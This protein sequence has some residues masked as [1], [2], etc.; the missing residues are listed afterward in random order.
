MMATPL[1]TSTGQDEDHWGSV[2]FEANY[3][4]LPLDVL[5]TADVGGRRLVRHLYPHRDGTQIED[6]GAVARK[7]RCKILFFPYGPGDTDPTVYFRQFMKIVARPEAQFFSHPITGTYLARVGEVTYNAEA[8]PRDTIT[9]ECTFEEDTL[10]PAVFEEALA[11]FG[12]ISMSEI[13]ASRQAITDVIAGMPAAPPGG[14]LTQRAY[15]G[16]LAGVTAAA[17][18]GVA[19]A[20]TWEDPTKRLRDANLELAQTITEIDQKQQDL[21]TY[22]D[23]GFY[24]LIT[25]CNDF[26]LSLMQ[27]WRSTQKAATII[28]VTVNSAAPLQIVAAQIYGAA[29]NENNVNSILS[30]N[31]IRNP[32]RIDAG[33]VLRVPA[34]QV[35]PSRNGPANT[36]VPSGRPNTVVPSS[37]V[38]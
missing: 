38:G 37:L 34:P 1:A 2:L 22:Q 10:T 32:F 17:D 14:Y 30:L 19:R 21:G 3:G 25:S 36:V 6:M 16:G 33:T 24:P 20:S 9:V 13:L 7:T 35:A 11:F 26:K 31:D 27:R 23:V 8:A 5:S 29:D 12:T 4:G 15:V 18:S 28:E